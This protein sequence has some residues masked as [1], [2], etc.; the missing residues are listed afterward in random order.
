MT[1]SCDLL[2]HESA[3]GVE[4]MALDEALLDSVADAPDHG[5]FR[6]YQWSEPTLTLGYFQSISEA[7]AEPRWRDVPIVRRLTGGG[8]LWHHHEVTYALILPARLPLA[9]RGASLYHAVHSAIAKVLREHGLDVHR[10]GD[11]AQGI[12]ALANRPFL[13][14][15]DRDAE[16]LVSARSKV[17]GSAQRRRAGAVLQHGSILLARSPK[18]PE[19]PGASN[20]AAVSSDVDAWAA[21]LREQIPQEL[22]LAPRSAALPGSVSLRAEELAQTIYRNPNWNRRR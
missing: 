13:C 1:I 16:D 20:L 5:V 9:A 8:A 10:R 12:E 15:S 18:T 6:T 4:N 21:V 3:D 11:E 7:E 14:F 17:V 19:L 22:G 2:P